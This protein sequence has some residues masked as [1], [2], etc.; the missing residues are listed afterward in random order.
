GTRSTIRNWNSASAPPPHRSGTPGGR[1]WRLS[2]CPRWRRGFRWQSF[3]R[4][5]SPSCSGAPIP[6]RPS[7]AIVA[8]ASSCLPWADRPLLPG[9]QEGRRDNGPRTG[10]RHGPWPWP[11]RRGTWRPWR[12]WAYAVPWQWL[13]FH[14]KK[15][16]EAHPERKEAKIV[17]KRARRLGGSVSVVLVVLL[18]LMAALP[19]AAAGDGSLERVRRAGQL[20]VGIEGAFPPFNMFDET[21][22]LVG[23][24]VDIAREIARRLGVDVQFV[25]TAWEGIVVGLLIGSYDAIISSL[26]ITPERQE[27]VAFTQTYY[28]SGAQIVVPSGSD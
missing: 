20:V 15:A 14:D 2:T 7:W 22:E 28:R 16:R 3:T 26:A 9:Q 6:S 23:F 12:S 24:D 19:A 1:W 27:R 8:T 17:S 4:R 5:S 21:G 13:G 11:R 10:T 18:C 25:P